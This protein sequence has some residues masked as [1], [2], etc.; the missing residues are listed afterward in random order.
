MPITN[1][2]PPKRSTY[3]AFLRGINVGGHKQI[4]MS[5]LRRFFTGLGFSDVSTVIQSGNVLFRAPTSRAGLLTK[6]IEKELTKRI[7][8]EISVFL[9]TS[10][11]ISKLVADGVCP[12][13]EV[14]QQ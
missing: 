8:F 14:R 2:S 4:A 12:R 13:G 3:V 11:E 1:T 9:R 5:D 6:T 10:K 7:G